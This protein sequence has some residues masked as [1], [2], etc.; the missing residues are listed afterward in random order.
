MR[1]ANLPDL[2][3]L[4]RGPVQVGD[5]EESHVRVEGKGLFQGSG[6]HVPG[7]IL[8][9]DKDRLAAL[10]GDG[11]DRRIKG[12]VRAEDLMPL[13]GTLACPGLSVEGL[14]RK[15]GC[16]VQGC[17]ACGQGDGI[18]HA[19]AFCDLLFHRVDVGADGGDPVGAEGLLDVR[20]LL[21]MHRGACEP[22]LLRK[23]LK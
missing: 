20:K 12:H 15:A 1:T 4:S 21:A 19:A 14:P 6:I 16:Q 5:D 23:C 18:L 22:D 8:G 2:V 17:R 9:I 11:V 13:Q 7:V 3:D 10:I